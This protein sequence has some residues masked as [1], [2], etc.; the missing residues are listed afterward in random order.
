MSEPSN[1]TQLQEHDHIVVTSVE[2]K[3]Y[4]G[5]LDLQTDRYILQYKAD[6]S[7]YVIDFS[8]DCNA[9]DN[10][11]TSASVTLSNFATIDDASLM[12]IEYK[13]A[14]S[15]GS[16][17]NWDENTFYH[18]VKKYYYPKTQYTYEWD[19][20]Y[21][22]CSNNQSELSPTSNTI[23]LSLINLSA[24]LQPEYGGTPNRFA[25]GLTTTVTRKKVIPHIDAR[26]IQPSGGSGSVTGIVVYSGNPSLNVKDT[27]DGTPSSSGV[28]TDP[29]E[30][31]IYYTEETVTLWS[32][33]APFIEYGTVVDTGF[34]YNQAMGSWAFDSSVQ[35]VS[36]MLPISGVVMSTTGYKLATPMIYEDREFP[37]DASRK[38]VMDFIVDQIYIGGHYWVD[39]GN[40]LYTRGK[41]T[42]WNAAISYAEYGQLVMNETRSYDDSGVYNSVNVISNTTMDGYEYTFFGRYENPNAEQTINVRAMYM[43]DNTIQSDAECVARAQYELNNIELGHETFTVTLSDNYC[44]SLMTA[45]ST[46]V[47]GCIEYVT[48]KGDTVHCLLDKVSYSSN[49]VTLVMRV[50]ETEMPEQ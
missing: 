48:L 10:T 46:K 43:E 35:D 33:A 24:L 29:T 22:V 19:M 4:R 16:G 3:T 50:F 44:G 31:D 11:R 18:L 42:N 47:G 25:Q 5:V 27:E 23:T 15:G 9:D 28:Y 14:S 8:Y 6:W 12:K 13:T 37:Y 49:T 45:T 1:E 7:A 36:R 34:L 20:G 30:W 38:D 32:L 40:R 21:F 17:V 41:Q 2:F 39:E 26:K